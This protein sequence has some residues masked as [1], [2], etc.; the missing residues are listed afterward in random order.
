VGW[1]DRFVDPLSRTYDMDP[2]RRLRQTIE[3]INKSH[4]NP[5]IIRFRM[6]GTGK[7]VIWELVN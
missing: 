1:C 2:K 7:G 5:A 3:D 4:I 6:D